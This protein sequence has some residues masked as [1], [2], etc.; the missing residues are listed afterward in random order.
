MRPIW[1]KFGVENCTK[2]SDVVTMS[3]TILLSPYSAMTNVI[4]RHSLLLHV[5]SS[6]KSS[7]ELQDD[8]TEFFLFFFLSFLWRNS[9]TRA[10]AASFFMFL[11]RTQWHTT[12]VWTPLD[13]GSAGRRDLYL[14]THSFQKRQASMPPAGFESAISASDRPQTL[15]LDRLVTEIGLFL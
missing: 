3:V 5:S 14:T 6:T 7:V 8:E 2:T 15:P 13:E 12:F 9:P 10:R 11:D 4:V 1:T